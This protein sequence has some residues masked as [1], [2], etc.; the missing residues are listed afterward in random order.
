MN[1]LYYF[2]EIKILRHFKF[3]CK[4]LRYLKGTLRKELMFKSRGNIQVEA[5]MNIDWEINI[6]NRRFTS[7]YFV[8]VD[9]N[10]VA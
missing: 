2:E 10:L 5:Y 9:R 7:W 8:F 4:I 1:E 6:N 3:F